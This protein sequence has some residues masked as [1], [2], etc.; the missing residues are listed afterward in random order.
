VLRGRTLATCY[1]YDQ[2]GRVARTITEPAWTAEDRA[3]ML[4]LQMHEQSLCSGCGEPKGRAWHPDMDGWYEA[5]TYE[6]NACS[7]IQDRRVSYYE[8]VDTRPL[9][10]LLP[11]NMGYAVSAPDSHDEDGGDG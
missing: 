11:D 10:D 2:D 7:V 3:L 9:D 8:V 5:A 1:E 4:A 6:C